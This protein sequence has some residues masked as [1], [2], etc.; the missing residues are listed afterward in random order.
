MQN[1]QQQLCMV[2]GDSSESAVSAAFPSSRQH[3]VGAVRGFD[4][5]DQCTTSKRDNRC[6]RLEPQDLTTL[7]TFVA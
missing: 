5:T 1:W 7:I 4:N 2:G 6:I 3:A